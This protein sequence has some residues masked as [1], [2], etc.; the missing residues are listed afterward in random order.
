MDKSPKNSRLVKQPLNKMQK[1][2]LDIVP[3]GT[4]VEVE[5]IVRSFPSLRWR[6]V[7]NALQDL[8]SEGKIVLKRQDGESRVLVMKPRSEGNLVKFQ[9]VKQSL[10][11]N[12]MS[13]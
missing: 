4:I 8:R 6:D 10:L 9:S 3:P 2:V 12:K 11:T 5:E 7:L 1:S 13:F